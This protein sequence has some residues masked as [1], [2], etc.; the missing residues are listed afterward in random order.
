MSAQGRLLTEYNAGAL[1]FAGMV[2]LMVFIAALHVAQIGR[3][4]AL[5]AACAVEQAEVER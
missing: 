2:I 3:L 4:D 1:F 5:E